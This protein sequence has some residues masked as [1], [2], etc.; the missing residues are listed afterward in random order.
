ML[1]VLNF[2]C[3]SHGK[4]NF[5]DRSQDGSG[6]MKPI[7]A[8]KKFLGC[9]KIAECCSTRMS[10]FPSLHCKQSSWK[11]FQ[12]PASST[13]N[14]TIS[15]YVDYNKRRRRRTSMQTNFIVTE[16]ASVEINVLQH[17]SNIHQ[18]NT[19]PLQVCIHEKYIALHK[20]SVVSTTLRHNS[21]FAS[22]L[23]LFQTVPSLYLYVPSLYSVYCV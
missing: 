16:E 15:Q 11:H 20:Q 22:K 10:T 19:L 7:H 23:F 17:V 1:F 2:L 5:E 9:S 12:S 14:F 6:V 8:Q 3:T 18:Q 13:E 4:Q 21:R